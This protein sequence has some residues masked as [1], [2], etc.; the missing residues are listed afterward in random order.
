MSERFEWFNKNEKGEDLIL[1]LKKHGELFL[2]QGRSIDGVVKVLSN[3]NGRYVLEIE[4]HVLDYPL[5]DP[6]IDDIN[7]NSFWDVAYYFGVTQ[8]KIKNFLLEHSNRFEDLEVL[9]EK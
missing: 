4:D 7:A 5:I 8:R 9:W 1:I 3:I 6:I 2:F